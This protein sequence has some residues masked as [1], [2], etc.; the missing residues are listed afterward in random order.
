[1]SL[2]KGYTLY[3]EENIRFATQQQQGDDN[4]RTSAAEGHNYSN[5]RSGS[6]SGGST[7]ESSYY[8]IY[9]DDDGA[10]IAPLL[11][12]RQY[13]PASLRKRTR[14]HTYSSNNNQI[15]PRYLYCYLDTAKC[16]G[17]NTDDNANYDRIND[18]YAALDTPANLT[19]GWILEVLYLSYLLSVCDVCVYV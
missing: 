8:D 5:S 1:M 12:P 15:I 16:C 9:R 19:E 17:N 4:V 2:H 6:V 3:K 7:S 11:L 10:E 14:S 18:E 13:M